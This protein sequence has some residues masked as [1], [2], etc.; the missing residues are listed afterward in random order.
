MSFKEH[1]LRQG[2]ELDLLFIEYGGSKEIDKDPIQLIGVRL[3][4]ASPFAY[5]I[6]QTHLLL[7]PQENRYTYHPPPKKV[8]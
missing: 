5:I 6:R 8:T 4:G 7:F 2:N 1:H 3:K